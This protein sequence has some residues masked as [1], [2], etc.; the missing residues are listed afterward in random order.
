MATQKLSRSRELAAKVI[1]AAFQI[2]KEKGGEA[3]GRDVIAEV[4][5]RVL[6]DD[7]AKA[8]YEKSGYVRWQSILHF[9]KH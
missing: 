4:E 7:W 5:R 6:L 9:F 1:F 8:T 3:P 2:L